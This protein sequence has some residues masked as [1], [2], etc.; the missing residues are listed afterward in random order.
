MMVLVVEDDDLVRTVAVEALAEEGF[1]ITEAATVEEALARCADIAADVLF[2][3]IRQPGG[4]TG[5][6]IAE[7]CRERDPSLPVIYATGFS[8]DEPR[9]VAGS[10]MLQKPYRPEQVVAAIRN[11]TER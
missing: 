4:G 7:H 11:L 6:D 5:W 3:D 8:G 1:E 9:P 10:I 2:T